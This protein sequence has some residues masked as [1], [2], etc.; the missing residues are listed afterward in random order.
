MQFLK[1][2]Q[3]ALWKFCAC[4]KCFV[5]ANANSHD[6]NKRKKSSTKTPMQ[7]NKKGAKNNNKHW[8]CAFPLNTF[9]VEFNC[10]YLFCYCFHVLLIFPHGNN[11]FNSIFYLAN[12]Y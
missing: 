12:S 2:R 3:D 10:A 1:T 7:Q 5:S 6:D 8:T 9:K 11:L 4:N